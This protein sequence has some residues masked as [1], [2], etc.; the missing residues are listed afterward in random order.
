MILWIWIEI[1]VWQFQLFESQVSMDAGLFHPCFFDV[2][3]IFV[4]I[5]NIFKYYFTLVSVL[6][7]IPFMDEYKYFNLPV[8]RQVCVSRIEVPDLCPC[9]FWRRQV[10]EGCIRVVKLVKL[11]KCIISSLK[12]Y[13]NH[14]YTKT[15]SLS[16]WKVAFPFTADMC[17]SVMYVCLPF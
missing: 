17:S 15:N 4:S 2:L 8:C 11:C 6:L 9:N 13:S 10:S 16:S 1:H 5:F 3:V 12:L 14:T 7:L